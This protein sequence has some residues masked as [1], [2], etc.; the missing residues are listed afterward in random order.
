LRRISLGEQH[1]PHLLPPVPSD[2][3]SCTLWVLRLP[4][5]H[6]CPLCCCCVDGS[7]STGACA[8]AC[9]CCNCSSIGWCPTLSRSC[10]TAA[11]P[12]RL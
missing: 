9:S 8:P 7:C 10:S 11:C 3:N 4:L 6:C 2:P 5:Q 1:T 12:P